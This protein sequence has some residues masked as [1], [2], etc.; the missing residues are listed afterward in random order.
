MS[1]ALRALESLVFH[2]TIPPIYSFNKYI[3]YTCVKYTNYNNTIHVACVK[4]Y[5]TSINPNDY[6]SQLIAVGGNL[7][8][9]VTIKLVELIA[10]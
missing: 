1:L 5:Y 4:G 9:P 7:V 10:I 2:S 3:F 6:F 8:G